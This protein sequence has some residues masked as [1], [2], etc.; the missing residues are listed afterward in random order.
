[1]SIVSDSKEP[2]WWFP[3]VL[4]ATAFKANTKANK[5]YEVQA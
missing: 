1:M 5:F 4:E 3:N 2:L